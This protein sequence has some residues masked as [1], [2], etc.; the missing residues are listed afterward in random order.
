MDWLWS[1]WRYRYIAR[2]AH[3]EGC[4]FCQ[5]PHEEDA[6]ALIMRTF[7]PEHGELQHAQQMNL[8]VAHAMLMLYE[9]TG[10]SEYLDWTQWLVA[11]EEAHPKLGL[12]RGMRAGRE[13]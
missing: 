13:F 8:G 2:A 10:R 5:R 12:V 6:A 4:V 9:A 1:P 3:A 7:G 11:T